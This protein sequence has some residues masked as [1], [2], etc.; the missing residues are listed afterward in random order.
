MYKEDIYMI[1]EV[2]I[3]EMRNEKFIVEVA[4]GKVQN[5]YSCNYS[6]KT[7]LAEHLW[8]NAVKSVYESLK[9]EENKEE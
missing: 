1:G 9:A 2:K 3:T 7:P 6:V 4:H 8:K 5:V